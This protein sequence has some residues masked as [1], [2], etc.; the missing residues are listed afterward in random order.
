M[1]NPRAPFP[2]ALAQPP[3]GRVLL[4]APHADDDV[5]GPGGTIRLHRQAG[6]EVKVVVLYD[7]AAGDPEG[8]YGRD[9]LVALRQEEA[10]RGGAHLG[11]DDYEFWGY[12]EGHMP[13]PGEFQA[14]VDRVKATIQSYQPGVI[15]APWVGEY[16]LDHHIASRVTRAAI[17]ELGWD[18]RA[19]GYEVWTPLI[20][21]WI[22]DISPVIEDKTAALSEHKSQLEY[23]DFLHMALGLSAQRSLYL[24]KGS[25][26]GE[27]FCSLIDPDT[28]SCGHDH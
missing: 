12:P 19:L 20:A 21:R 10:R 27:A 25:R 14:A 26:H 8:R 18:G 3:A 28:E 6:D 4:L 17:G 5:L 7:G 13:G 11:L 16:H 1:R 15:Y 22:V 2:E 9:E 23:S 24:P